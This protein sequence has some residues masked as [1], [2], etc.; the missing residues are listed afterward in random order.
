[1]VGFL[2]TYSLFRP[3]TDQLTACIQD[4]AVAMNLCIATKMNGTPY[5]LLKN[6][7]YISWSHQ[8]FYPI[9]IS[10]QR[11]VLS[12]DYAL[13]YQLNHSWREF[14]R[15]ISFLLICLTSSFLL[16]IHFTTKWKKL[17]QVA[18]VLSLLTISLTG[19]S[20]IAP[21]AITHLGRSSLYI[22]SGTIVIVAIFSVYFFQR[23]KKINRKSQFTAITS[24]IAL[25][26]LPAIFLILNQRVQLFSEAPLPYLFMGW[27][28]RFILSTGFIS[29]CALLITILHSSGWK[30]R[31]R[32]FTYAI[33][34]LILS[35]NAG[36]FLSPTEG[37]MIGAMHF[38]LFLLSDMTIEESRV[39]F[40]WLVI[41]SLAIALY[42]TL[43][44]L[45]FEKSISGDIL[46]M[47]NHFS[48]SFAGCMTSVI[49]LFL[50]NS[51][52]LPNVSIGRLRLP[53]QFML[54]HK[55]EVLVLGTLILSFVAIGGMT[56]LI[57]SNESKTDNNNLLSWAQTHDFEIRS[58]A[59]DKIKVDSFINGILLGNDHLEH[60]TFMPYSVFNHFNTDST[61]IISPPHL[62]RKTDDE[63]IVRMGPAQ[64]SII[65]RYHSSILSKLLN[66]YVFL[67]LLAIGVIYLF[68]S[69][70]IRPLQLLGQ[71]LHNIDI[72][73]QNRRID[74]RYKD[75][76]GHLIGQY[77]NMLDQ[78]D[79][80]AEAL[81]QNERDHAWREM[82]KQVAHE[83]KNPL[84]PMKLT[85]QHM[86]M[87][88]DREQTGF[89]QQVTRAS[90][91]M[92]E[93]IDNLTRIADNFSRFGQMPG[94]SNEKV[95]LN[96]VITSAHDLFR[97]REDIEIKCFVPIDDLF[98][99]A[100]KDHLIRILNNIIKNAIQAIPHERLGQ[101]TI[102]LIRDEHDATISITDNGTGISDEE[103]AKVFQPNFTTK[104][105]GTGLGLAMCSK[106]VE[107]MNGK[108]YFETEQDVGTTFFIVIPLMRIDANYLPEAMSE[109]LD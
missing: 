20:M 58:L 21:S 76:I 62:F 23:F 94:A 84:T 47:F 73:K 75:E 78:L 68:T 103:K 77:N 85:I 104:S 93:Q 72:G 64:S 98:V 69:H 66:V 6:E 81:A 15:Y 89:S 12:D 52:L 29:V 1:M 46:E 95:L 40:L 48:L 16:L 97:K 100:D 74:W 17:W 92:I 54:R 2:L 79:H 99:F 4:D 41:W 88:A 106:M 5:V 82:A 50:S 70:L 39:N 42:M 107:S 9:E 71:Q 43:I 11:T 25:L 27:I 3:Q 44:W 28:L 49:I 38:V 90:N 24:S 109:E 18:A 59:P 87:K 30:V 36:I 7:R 22:L 105:S 45:T 37:I 13:L 55:F 108:I 86:I 19:I 35:L 80:S 102:R 101:I 8:A 34:C 60:P 10:T 61:D 91:T 53:S 65:S 26:I 63:L 14:L 56:Y 96:E 67:F 31:T 33:I 51:T 83:I 57:E 32:I